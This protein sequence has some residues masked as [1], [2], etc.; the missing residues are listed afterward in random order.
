M[1]LSDLRTLEA[2][3]G[4]VS[5]DYR[6]GTYSSTYITSSKVLV[7]I[8]RYSLSRLLILFHHLKKFN[9]FHHLNLP[10]L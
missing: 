10:S 6:V 1:G 7:V 5:T 2:R 4:S 3:A 9:V 8:L